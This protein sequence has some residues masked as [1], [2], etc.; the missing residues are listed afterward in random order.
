MGSFFYACMVF[1]WELG[2]LGGGV[3]KAFLGRRFLLFF[4]PP[5]FSKRLLMK[6]CKIRVP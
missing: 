4:R 6:T 5:L 1:S 2:V 3:G